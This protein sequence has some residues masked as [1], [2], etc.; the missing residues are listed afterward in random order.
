M[1]NFSTLDVAIDIV[2]FNLS[3]MIYMYYNYKIIVIIS[4]FPLAARK[5]HDL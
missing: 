2:Y 3:S 1:S 4:Q 5:R